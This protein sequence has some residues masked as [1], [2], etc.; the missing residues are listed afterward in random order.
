M[1]TVLTKKQ[2]SEEDT[3]LH[4]ITPAITSKWNSKKITMETKITDGRVNVKGNLTRRESPKR[5]DYLLYL[6]DNKPIAV[7]EAKDNNHSVSFGLQQS[8]TYGKK[9]LTRR[10]RAENIQKK[11]IFSKYSGAAKEVLETLLVKYMDLGIKEIEKTEILKLSD[12]AKFGAP[13]KIAKLFGGNNEY[14][15]AVLELKDDLYEDEVG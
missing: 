15:A 7:V 10:E 1:S 11:D 3:K 4:F 14:K 6:S 9:P 12:F 2:M 13:S 8:M 5:V